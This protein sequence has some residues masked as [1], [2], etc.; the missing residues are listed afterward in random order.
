VERDGWQ[1]KLWILGLWQGYWQKAEAYLRLSGGVY[2]QARLLAAQSSKF[3][4]PSMKAINSFVLFVALSIAVT[5][6]QTANNATSQA[7]ATILAPTTPQIVDRGPNHQLWQ[8]Q[9][10]DLSPQGAVVTR[11]HQYSFF[12]QT[13]G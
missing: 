3:H 11:T 9:E 2:L 5:R 1:V 4:V 13:S 10:Y 12:S 6:A 7:T 8:W